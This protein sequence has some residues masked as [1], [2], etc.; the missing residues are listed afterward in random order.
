MNFPDAIEMMKSVL[1]KFGE[2]QTTKMFIEAVGFQ[3][4]YYQVL[5]QDGY[6][7][8]E[9]VKVTLDKRT[10]LELVTKFIKDGTILF[11]SGKPF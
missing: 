5:F 1:D 11:P 6:T 2:K 4:A 7:Q 10:R 8:V 9:P 3:E